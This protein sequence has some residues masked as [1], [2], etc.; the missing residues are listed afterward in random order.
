MS[1]LCS[2]ALCVA[3]V[4]AAG[5]YLVLARDLVGVVLRLGLIGAA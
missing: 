4:A 3:A 1:A 2:L 5:L